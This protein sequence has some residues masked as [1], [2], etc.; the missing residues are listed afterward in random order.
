MILSMVNAG[1]DQGL[2]ELNL[3]TAILEWAIYTMPVQLKEGVGEDLP[4]FRLAGI[5]TGVECT[6][7]TNTGTYACLRMRIKYCYPTIHSYKLH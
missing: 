7:R 5:D 4:N 2:G 1:V 3:I 6:S